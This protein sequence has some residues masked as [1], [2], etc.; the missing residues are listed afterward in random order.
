MAG[1]ALRAEARVKQLCCLGLGGQAV[2]PALLRELHAFIPSHAN[3]FFW[4]DENGELA[5]IYDESPDSI[6]VGPLYINEF[7]NR[8]E[9]EVNPGFTFTMR[10][11]HGV[12]SADSLISVSRREFLDSDIYN[13]VYRPLG[14]HDF[15]RLMVREGGRA[16][17][18]LQLW[19]APGESKFS[20]QDKARLRRLEPFIAHALS[21]ASE[22]EVPLVEREDGGVIVVDRGGL[23]QHI[24][25]HARTLLFYALHPQVAP[26]KVG[27]RFGLL[28]PAVRRLCDSLVA[29][30]ES[31]D[32]PAPPMCEVVNGWG[33]FTF[34]AHWLEGANSP[35]ALIGITVSHREPLP[36]RLMRRMIDLPLTSRQMHA[37]LLT[38][39]GYSA[40]TMAGQMEIS[41]HTAIAYRRQVYA[42]MDV[43]SRSELL[44]KLLAL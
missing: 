3:S 9:C 2:M 12:H 4:A 25:P 7:Y 11:H 33:R 10:H 34:R 38:A 36:L 13:L 5:N 17:G 19:R 8:R 37:C 31:R 39:S 29:A 26:G 22:S 28:P 32:P 35:S 23:V 42:R 18:A 40:R 41:E 15:V 16:L 1:P 20:R 43:H 27:V 44:G 24:S 14:Y 30:F 6:K 21:P